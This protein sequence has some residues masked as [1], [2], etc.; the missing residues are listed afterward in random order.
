MSVEG[1]WSYEALSNTPEIASGVIVLVAGQ[2]LG[3]NSENYF[4]GSYTLIN[5]RLAAA[6]KLASHTGDHRT[7]FGKTD[8]FRLQIAG[9]VQNH[10]M[11]LAG[12]VVDEPEKKILIRCERRVSLVDR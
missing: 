10:L 2:V 9:E 7:V 8:N 5:N 4:A 6:V 11:E 12:Y 1:L 3:G